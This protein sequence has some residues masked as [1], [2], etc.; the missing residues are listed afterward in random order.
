MALSCRCASATRVM[1]GED[2]NGGVGVTAM[3]KEQVDVKP[4]DVPSPD[5]DLTVPSWPIADAFR[6][7][8]LVVWKNV[9][10][11]G[12]RPLA[13][14]L[15]VLFP[16][17]AFV[18]LAVLTPRNEYFDAGYSPNAPWMPPA[19]VLQHDVPTN[20]TT[21]DANLI[22]T[23]CPDAGH[24]QGP[25]VIVPFAPDTDEV[26]LL[27]TAACELRYHPPGV[28]IVG[29][30]HTTVSKRRRLLSWEGKSA[31]GGS[32]AVK[33]SSTK[34]SDTFRRRLLFG[35]SDPPSGPPSPP[36]RPTALAR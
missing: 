6:Q 11:R 10:L 9:Q 12:N 24:L 28:D 36:T 29:Y 13:T 34:M 14:I 22:P 18:A 4:F 32:S 33:S 5:D 30:S 3:E 16:L 26:R 15:E 8:L 21:I 2:V 20:L 19:C 1:G 23:V 25:H 27:M 17:I 7:V 35:P 31:S